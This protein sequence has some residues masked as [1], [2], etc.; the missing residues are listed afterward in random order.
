MLY[1]FQLIFG[2]NL[3]LK[4]HCRC[5]TKL[6]VFCGFKKMMD[7][8]WKMLWFFQLSNSFEKEKQQFRCLLHE[9]Q[10]NLRKNEE[11]IWNGA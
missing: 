2:G 10:L 1:V 3:L 7:A 5:L 6:I 4:H 9:I 8:Y 11:R